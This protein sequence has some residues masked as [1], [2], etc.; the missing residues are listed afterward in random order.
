MTG[1]G[2]TSLFSLSHLIRWGIDEHV[3]GRREIAF[4]KHW[5]IEKM[6]RSRKSHVSSAIDCSTAFSIQ[7]VAV[8]QV[9]RSAGSPKQH[10]CLSSLCS[11]ADRVADHR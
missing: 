5:M 9:V 3:G 2:T 8:S 11:D 1:P 6:S 7:L 10:L 4:G